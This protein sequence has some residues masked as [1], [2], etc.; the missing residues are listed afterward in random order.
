M[1]IID[2]NS[3][4]SIN[5]SKEYFLDTNVLYWYVYPRYG[6]TKKS[7]EYQ[8]KPYYDFVDRLVSDGNPLCTSVYNIS[9]LL[10]IIEKNEFAIIPLK[11]IERILWKEK[12]YRTSYIQL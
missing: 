3:F 10:N 6:L 5:N 7:V 11:I 2:I 12:N 4:S 1:N 9:E 8:A